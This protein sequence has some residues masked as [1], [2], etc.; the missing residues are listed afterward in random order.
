MTPDPTA[1][2]WEEALE[3]LQRAERL[4]RRFFHLQDARRPLPAWEPPVDVFE[5]DGQLVILVALPGVAAEQ[6]EILLDEAV[7]IVR[8]ARS[9]PALCRRGRIHRLEI[10]HGYFERRIALPPGGFELRQ[11]SLHDGCLALALAR[12]LSGGET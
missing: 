9:I 7:L 5:V 2:M 6:V 10:P 4:Q 11:Q 8:G 12:T 1:W 3:M